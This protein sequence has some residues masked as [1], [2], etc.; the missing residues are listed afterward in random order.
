M[1]D[2]ILNLMSE[3]GITAQKLSSDIG[4]AS[5]AVSE[6]KK[7]KYKP[8]TEN[9]IKLSEY[10]GVTADY[11]LFGKIDAAASRPVNN[12]LGNGNIGIGTHNTTIT[13]NGNAPRALS[14]ME[15]EL[16]KL[17]AALDMKKKTELLTY[18][19]GLENK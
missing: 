15:S 12:V 10:F 13:I 9:I 19:Y 8:T 6:W 11:I 3:R 5:T 7:G 18:A 4:I 1:I 17:F 2:R 14:E 16:L